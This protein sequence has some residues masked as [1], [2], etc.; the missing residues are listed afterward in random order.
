MGIDT[1]SD[2]KSQPLTIPLTYGML[3][4]YMKDIGNHPA[5]YISVNE[6][7]NAF[8]QF[9]DDETFLLML[10]TQTHD[11]QERLPKGVID[12]AHAINAYLEP[13]WGTQA[14]KT[15]STFM[16]KIVAKLR[17]VTSEQP[18]AATETE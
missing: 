11:S 15:V 10:M 9:R 1:L 17:G 6:D 16:T 8:K 7:K 14:R 2:E 4:T 5:R 12:A 13:S 3:P 18:A